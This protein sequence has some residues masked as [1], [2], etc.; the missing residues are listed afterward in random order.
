MTPALFSCGV[1]FWMRLSPPPGSGLAGPNLAG[2]VMMKSLPVSFKATVS[3]T[4][5]FLRL[6]GLDL[7]L[8]PFGKD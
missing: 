8:R 2:F 6:I 7:V 3:I 1:A 5:P 4:W